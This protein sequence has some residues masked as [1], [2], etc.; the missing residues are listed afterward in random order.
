MHQLALVLSQVADHLTRLA[1]DGD[2]HAINACERV[3]VRH[4]EVVLELPLVHE[5]DGFA[6][7]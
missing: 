3:E 7:R 4:S 5:L 2:R 1:A 6:V